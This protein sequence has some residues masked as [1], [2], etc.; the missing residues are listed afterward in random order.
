MAAMST[1]E[2]SDF[3]PIGI[4]AGYPQAYPLADMNSIVLARH[5]TFQYR[6]ASSWEKLGNDELKKN[7]FTIAFNSC[8]S[9]LFISFF[10]V[11]VISI[12]SYI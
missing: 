7:R 1:L 4:K 10:R 9:Q 3:P 12:F 8:E 2:S 11:V 6:I 5:L